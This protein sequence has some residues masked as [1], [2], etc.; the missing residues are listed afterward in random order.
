MKKRWKLAAALILA[1]VFASAAGQFLYI[2]QI[3]Q[4][5]AGKVIRFHVVANSDSD[6]DQQ[7]K[8]QVRDRIGA[9]LSDQLKNAGSIQESRQII[10]DHIDEIRGCAQET[11]LE[12]GADYSVQAF[13][14]RCRFPEKQYGTVS[15]PAGQYEA[16][17][18]VLG[19]GQGHNWWCVMYPNL[20]FSGSMYR[21]DDEKDSREM[22][23]V[24]DPEE[25][26]VVMENK[27]Y[28]VKFRFLTFLNDLSRS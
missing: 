24:L 28:R 26:R 3:Q 2:Q 7:L 6:E 12:N 21:T 23:R 25:Y 5:I 15:L 16:L 17:E 18:V 14:G 11:V 1:V 9:L 19:E 22:K 4:R 10:T 27:N 8:L 20:C 13:L